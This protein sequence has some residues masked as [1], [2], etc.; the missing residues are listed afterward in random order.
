MYTLYK[1][2]LN[3]R[4]NENHITGLEKKYLL[5]VTEFSYIVLKIRFFFNKLKMT[6]EIRMEFF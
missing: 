4:C 5:I 2:N 1:E 3:F 6:F